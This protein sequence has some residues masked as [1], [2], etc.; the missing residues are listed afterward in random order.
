[1]TIQPS[2][3][4]ALQQTANSNRIKVTCEKD[5]FIDPL[6]EISWDSI[7]DSYAF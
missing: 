5:N 7:E 6:M 4:W 1:M 3:Q 2:F